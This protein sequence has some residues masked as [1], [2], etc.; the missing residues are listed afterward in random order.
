MEIEA[1]R[2]SVTCPRSSGARVWHRP[3]VCRVCALGMLYLPLPPP[4]AIHFFPSSFF[5]PPVHSTFPSEPVLRTVTP[6]RCTDTGWSRKATSCSQNR[7]CPWYSLYGWGQW[8][9]WFSTGSF[10]DLRRKQQREV[11]WRLAAS[12]RT[13][14]LKALRES[15]RPSQPLPTTQTPLLTA[16]ALTC[17]A[18]HKG[19]PLSGSQFPHL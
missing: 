18:L 11:R 8:E 5:H 13:S 17:G 10:G 14:P 9:N 19:L 15:G 12:Y 6:A 7:N 3:S 2:S 4:C 16:G 1:Q